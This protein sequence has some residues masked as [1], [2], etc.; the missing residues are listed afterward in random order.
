LTSRT[1]ARNVAKFALSKKSSDVL[2]MDLR[3]LSAPADFFVL[4]SADS[5]THVRAIADAVRHGTDEIGVRLWQSEGFTAMTW[6]ILDY[7]DVV[8][9]VFKRDVRAFYNLER[10]WGDA[11][12]TP[13]DD[14]PPP[15]R[16]A[17]EPGKKRTRK[18]AARTT[19]KPRS[20]K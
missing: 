6:I 8:V 10:L 1:L 9:H 11:V 18:T 14:T 3:K 5:D 7:V 4:C 19:R 17:T 13:V 20:P 15:T 2:L 16:A 12:I